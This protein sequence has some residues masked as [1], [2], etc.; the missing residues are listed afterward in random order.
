MIPL[1]SRIKLMWVPSHQGITGNE[2]ADELAKSP[3]LL[4]NITGMPYSVAD[5][6]VEMKVNIQARW[7]QLS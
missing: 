3:T 2:N 7:Q 1:K 6:L 4:D 5:I